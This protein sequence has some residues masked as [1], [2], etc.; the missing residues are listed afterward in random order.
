MSRDGNTHEYDDDHYHLNGSLP[1]G[2]PDNL[3]E[4]LP[5]DEGL[6]YEEI[7]LQQACV[8]QSYQEN[9]TN[10]VVGSDD[11][12]IS[13]SSCSEDEGG[14]SRAES[15]ISQEAMDEAYARSLQELGEEFDEFFITEF[16]SSPHLNQQ[17]ID[18]TN[19]RYEELLN[20][21][22]TVGVENVGL[23]AAQISQ[24]PIT[25]CTSGMFSN[26][27][28]EKTA[29]FVKRRWFNLEAKTY[30][31]G[32]TK[33]RVLRTSGGKLAPLP[34]SVAI[35]TGVMECN[36]YAISK[37]LIKYEA[38][39]GI[40]K[41]DKSVLHILASSL[42]FK[43]KGKIILLS[44]PNESDCPV[45]GL[46]DPLCLL[47]LLGDATSIS[48]ELYLERHGPKSALDAVS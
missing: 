15:V 43:E 5:Q 31:R 22:E 26:N 40:G 1:A 17:D 25:I 21:T 19:M 32:L 35:T 12:H 29:L 24:L 41:H 11:D 13:E 2:I 39:F 8:Y 28:E 34:P 16:N 33:S 10:R 4:F 46:L 44:Y 42:V 48:I 20:L 6:S 3:K 37:M 47:A 14:S 38:C 18:T 27:Q 9:G 30:Q 7:I 23:S 36:V 45:T